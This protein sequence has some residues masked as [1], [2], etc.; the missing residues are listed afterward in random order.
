MRPTAAE[1]R[2]DAQRRLATYL[3]DHL[4]G[5][6]MGIALMRRMRHENDGS[7][8]ASVLDELIPE[9][10]EDRAELL[11]VVDA[12]GMRPG[13]FKQL[14]AVVAERLARFKLNGRLFRYSPLSRFE[15]LEAMALGI[16]GKRK[17]WLALG[18]LAGRRPVLGAFGFDALA[19]RA[20][21]QH[22]LVEAQR[23]EAADAAIA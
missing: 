3:D 1:R 23:M 4:A 8:L 6:A 21:R 13:R 20:E 2:P 15:E 11:A 12:L 10:E 18:N 5:A 7:P 19:R 14:L 16:L 9:L 17:M 22:E